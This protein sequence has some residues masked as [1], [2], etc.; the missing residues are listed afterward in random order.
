MIYEEHY[1]KCLKYKKTKKE[2][3]TLEN[4]KISLM[5]MVDLQAV[6]PKEVI[7]TNTKEDKMLKYVEELEETEI[8][9]EKNKKIE[10]EIKI[11]LK[12]KEKDLRKSKELLDKVYLYKYLEH[13][14]YYQV[15]IKINYGK[16]KTYDLINEIAENLEKIKI[17]EKNGKL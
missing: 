5:S 15:A 12:E 8:S 2:I 9:I 14:N 11:Q 6:P 7:G 3:N 13:L 17:A 4:K 1:L 10:E 16:T